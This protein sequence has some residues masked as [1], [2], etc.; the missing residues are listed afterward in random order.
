MPAYDKH[1]GV[2]SP[3]GRIYQTEYA[4]KS[5][6][7]APTGLALTAK[8]CTIFVSETVQSSPLQVLPPS[9]QM[10]DK[11]IS[12]LPIG[13][14]AD[15]RALISYLRS[16]AQSH[17]FNFEEPVPIQLLTEELSEKFTN[18]GKQKK[19]EQKMGRP[20]GCAVLLATKDELYYC[21]PA[22]NSIKYK[23]KAA[24]SGGLTAQEELERQWAKLPE[25]E[26]LQ[27]A[28]SIMKGV[29]EGGVETLSVAVLGE[30]G[31]RTLTVDEI[32]TLLI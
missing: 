22:G 2:F 23:A 7:L 18:F 27:I 11:H 29:I 10:I 3:E 25:K 32:K 21:D 15:A 13:Y 28:V 14:P 16:E 26:A 12:A 1:V 17:W 31:L 8:N 19:N 24:G 20:F 5:V 9:F 4:V 30:N 6:S